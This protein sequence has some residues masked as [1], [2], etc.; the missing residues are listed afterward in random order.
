MGGVSVWL[1]VYVTAQVTARFAVLNTD[2]PHAGISNSVTSARK[3]T[4]KSSFKV[5][6]SLP[7]LHQNFNVSTN[8]SKTP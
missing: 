1:G 7:D 6:V 5:L 4:S 2:N 8:F 3:I